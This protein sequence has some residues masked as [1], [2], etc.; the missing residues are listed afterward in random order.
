MNVRL[1]KARPYSSC[2]FY[3]REGGDRYQ[4]ATCVLV[5]ERYPKLPR[6]RFHTDSF[7]TDTFCR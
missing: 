7:N 6:S 1:L 3:I 4:F 5:F 2:L